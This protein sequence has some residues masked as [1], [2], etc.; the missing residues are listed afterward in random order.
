MKR[1][2][3]LVRKIV[4]MLEDHPSGSAPESKIDG[5]T[6]EEIGYHLYLLVDAGLA[7]GDIIRVG[8]E[9]PVA[10]INSLKSAG[11][12]FAESVSVNSPQARSS[13][14]SMMWIIVM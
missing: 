4:L 12:D 2:M 7:D 3:D 6:E 8:N 11:H 13:L 10:I 14:R 1:D 5:Y 9:T